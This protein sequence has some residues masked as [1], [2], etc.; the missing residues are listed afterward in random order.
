MKYLFF[1]YDGTLTHNG[2]ISE[3][4]KEALKK[5][6][7]HGHKIF[8]H[9]GRSKA[10]VPDDAFEIE[11][12]GMI[13]GKGYM[14]YGGKVLFEYRLSPKVLTR[15]LEY[16]DKRGIRV[17]WEGVEK[18]YSN[19]PNEWLV[20]VYENLPPRDDLRI[21]AVQIGGPVPLEDA[22][23]FPEADILSFPGYSEVNPKGVNK[24]TGLIF[25]E[26][27]LGVPHEDII[28][29]GDSENDLDMV[30]YA[31]TSVIMNHAPEFMWQYATIRTD[32]DEN[33]V[34]EGIE[35]VVFNN[36]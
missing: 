3:K 34:A 13:C 36:N 22:E 28:V 21:T 5:A 18:V 4:N 7:A 16:C 33:G 17:L 23:L 29:F 8:L 24:T 31:Q 26:T 25:L 35:K 6:K 14:E 27:Q 1:D 11:W 10:N 19:R 9:T 2:V 30:K 32:S 12:D 15:A 20:N